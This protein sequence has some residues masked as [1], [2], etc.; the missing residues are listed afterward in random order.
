MCRSIICVSFVLVGV[1]LGGHARAQSPKTP[2]IIALGKQATALVEV[3][4]P[5][6]EEGGSGTAFCIDKAGL[7]IT[8]AHVVADADGGRADIRIVLDAGQNQKRQILRAR[9]VRSDERLDLALLSVNPVP[10]L[11]PLLLG[12]DELLTETM[13]VRT[14]GFPFGPE[15]GSDITVLE[16]KIASLRR[17][18]GRLR[19]I[20]FDNRLN[21]GNSGGPVLGPDGKV[22]GV[23]RATLVEQ[24]NLKGTG[25][26]VAIPVGLNSAIPAGILQA[27][28]SA[29]V[30]LFNPPALAYKG[31]SDKVTWTIKVQPPMESAPLPDRLSV[32][33]TVATDVTP[34]RTFDAT[35]KGTGT[36]QVT[37]VPVPKQSESPVE[38]RVQIGGSLIETSVPDRAVRV[39]KASLLLSDLQRLMIG[40]NRPHVI[41]RK[42]EMVV[43]PI[44]N[45]GTVKAKAKRKTFTVDL[46]R[47]DVIQVTSAAAADPLRAIAAVVELKR[48]SEVLATKARHL[49]FPDAPMLVIDRARGVGMVVQRPPPPVIQTPNPVVRPDPVVD[50]A[51]LQMGGT[52]RADGVSRGAGLSITPPAV[53]MGDAHPADGS[54]EVTEVAHFR[55]HKGH[56]EI[57]VVSPD[58]R[59]IL[60]GAGDKSMI[61]WDRETGRQ[62]RRFGEHG[63]QIFS[64][65]FAPDGRR[66]LS[67]GED[68]IIRLWDL[69]TG[70]VVREFRGHSEYVMSLAF[71]PDGRRAYSSGGGFHSNIADG[72]DSAVRVWDVENGRQI[73]QLRGHRGI[74]LSLAVSAD[75]S[76]ILSGGDTIIL[77][78]A[79]TLTEIRRLA[80]H[81]GK[82]ASVAFLPDGQRVVSSSWDGTIRLWDVKTGRELHCFRGHPGGYTWMALSPDGQRLL[83][84]SWDGHELRLWDIEGRTQLGRVALDGSQPI[85]VA[86]TPDGRHAA[87]GS[88]DGLRIYRLPDVSTQ[89]SE[90]TEPLVRSLGAKLTDLVVGGGG[91]YL[92]MLLKEA[93]QVAIFDV[94]A[95]DVVKR[96]DVPSDE[97]L[98]AAGADKLILHYPATG[99]GLFQRYSLKTM[100]LEIK[101]QNQPLHGRIFQL[102]MG[103]DSDGPILACWSTSAAGTDAHRGCFIDPV[104]LKVLK[105]GPLQDPYGT[106][107]SQPAGAGVFQLRLPEIHRFQLRASPSGCLF[108]C[109]KTNGNGWETFALRSGEL[110]ITP[111][112]GGWGHALPGSDDKTIYGIYGRMLKADGQPVDAS[113]VDRHSREI[114]IPSTSPSYYLGVTGYDPNSGHHTGPLTM[115]IHLANRG[116]ELATIQDLDEMADLHNDHVVV[117]T[118]TLDRRFH[119]IP[120]ANLL[121]TIPH[122]NDRLVV[123]RL[124]LDR[125]IAAAR[126]PLLFVTSP[127][128][129]GARPGQNLAH[130]IETRSSKGAVR[131]ELTSGPPGLTV[132][133]EGSITWRVPLY[134]ETKEYDPIFAIS[135]AS[136]R[137]IFHSIK[138]KVE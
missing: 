44:S 123:R 111:V 71:A 1:V 23:A 119:F 6:A 14:F 24:A 72:T 46:S 69:E 70:A 79:N 81:T 93:R 74:V 53:A 134:R 89:K 16:S 61:L 138:I 60:S 65:A 39:G 125:A 137:Q 66:A 64:V 21:P 10:G 50:Q 43:G 15:L 99:H 133:R 80:G 67:A 68:P 86:F 51:R 36:Y 62:I 96:I 35:S 28:L 12:R 41:T 87:C 76:R 29:P 106:G 105:L 126:R 109:W 107:A 56:V 7:F 77:W 63:G 20:Q 3:S 100:D 52:L 26:S 85:R 132:T 136:G 30:I 37:F 128:E 104:S 118:I 19:E 22:V 131:F 54:S 127:S 42:G 75:G 5:G 25:I 27:F 59:Q 114:L 122:S 101:G 9:L 88:T 34:P 18:E 102:A 98:L 95:A 84:S 58:G 2:D 13:P 32:S 113:A 91:R 17:S 40:G 121:V 82:V 55:G 31:R 38:L 110:R 45:L 97:V 135:D 108:T 124:D 33:V 117:D 73:G 83:S 90:R 112:N 116:D 4:G 129:I 120:Q 130:Q 115:V 8:N 92:I 94:N 11:V 78:D 48:G 57:A 47:A 49:E 103:S